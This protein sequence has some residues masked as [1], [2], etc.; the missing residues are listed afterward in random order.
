MCLVAGAFAAT[1]ISMARMTPVDIASP[2]RSEVL[3]GIDPNTAAWYEIAQLPRIGETVG[4]RIVEHREKRLAARSRSAETAYSDIGGRVY[5]RPGDLAQVN[6][7]GVR[8]VQRIAP[9][10]RFD[11]RDGVALAD[12]Q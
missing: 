8:T 12:R 2:Q 10:L 3:T 11:E 5:R 7:I 1:L 9:F 6:G 4:R